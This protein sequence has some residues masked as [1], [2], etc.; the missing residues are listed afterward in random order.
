MYAGVPGSAPV[1][2]FRV[3]NVYKPRS[4]LTGLLC[5]G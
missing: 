1:P 4:P 3:E 5:K 2:G